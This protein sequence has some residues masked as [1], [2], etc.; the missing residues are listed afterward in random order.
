MATTPK[1]YSTG[2]SGSLTLSASLQVITTGQSEDS[3]IVVLS[4]VNLAPTSK[5]LTIADTA[6]NTLGSIFLPANAGNAIANPPIDLM[7]PGFGVVGLE[8]NPM[9]GYNIFLPAGETLQA[10]LNNI[11]GGAARIYWKRKDY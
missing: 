5:T 8:P 7:K 1:F 4:V 2:E 11:T 10:M 9:G 6:G 3:D